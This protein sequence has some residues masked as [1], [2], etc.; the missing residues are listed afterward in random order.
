MTLC[1][2]FNYS[3]MCDICINVHVAITNCIIMYMYDGVVSPLVA[4]DH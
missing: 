1:I 4:I 3:C 2:T